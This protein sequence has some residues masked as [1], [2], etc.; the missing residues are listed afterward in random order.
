MRRIAGAKQDL[1]AYAT[2]KLSATPGLRIFGVAPR[3][4]ALISFLIEG[5]MRTIWQP[6]LIWKASR[7]AAGITARIHWMQFH[8]VPATVA[9]NWRFTTRMP[10]LTR[11]SAHRF[12]RA[13]C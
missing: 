9:P 5:V 13:S 3:K 7:C 6:C 12:K 1:L 11:S 2:E 4:A 10:K 8:G